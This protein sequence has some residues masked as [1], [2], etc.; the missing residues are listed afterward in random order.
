MKRTH[1]VLV[2]AGIGLLSL[3]IPLFLMSGVTES[4]AQESQNLS[5]PHKLEPFKL[6]PTVLPNEHARP[7]NVL[8]EEEKES[9][10]LCARKSE[11]YS[12][13][14]V[15]KGLLTVSGR[16]K[17]AIDGG[18]AFEI[19]EAARFPISEAA[20]V[21]ASCELQFQFDGPGRIETIKTET[22]RTI[23][24]SGK[25]KLLLIERETESPV[26]DSVKMFGQAKF[27]LRNWSIAHAFDQV[28][29]NAESCSSIIAKDES[30]V[31]VEFCYEAIAHDESNIV[32]ERVFRA[33]SNDSANIT[34]LH[35]ADS[36]ETTGS[37]TIELRRK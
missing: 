35:A 8:P 24:F 34:I 26:R 23:D 13:K 15:G 10:A 20:I 9:L 16:S 18:D 37:G 25:G 2:L 31:R 32:T 14:I 12:L 29:V 27:V 21:T 19:D 17:I 11:P 6:T 1:L 30:K 7:R 3:T 36:I 5:Q 22:P 33:S 4:E 28:D